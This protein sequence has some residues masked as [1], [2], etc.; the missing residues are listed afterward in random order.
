VLGKSWQLD[1]AMDITATGRA[2]DVTGSERVRVGS[3]GAVV[4]LSSG[5]DG[6]LEFDTFVWRSSSSFDTFTNP[7]R[8]H[9]G[10]LSFCPA[11]LLS[12]RRTGGLMTARPSC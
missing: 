9:E 10:R 4:E 7:V 5:A 1:S 11:T 2:V 3:V 8:P 12:Y 6:D